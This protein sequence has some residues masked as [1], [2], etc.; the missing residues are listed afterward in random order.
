[1]IVKR[2][3]IDSAIDEE[4][5]SSGVKY[6]A[7]NIVIANCEKCL[8]ITEKALHWAERLRIFFKEKNSESLLIN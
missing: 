7:N 2:P 6:L 1:M 3:I 4:A 8:T 5:K